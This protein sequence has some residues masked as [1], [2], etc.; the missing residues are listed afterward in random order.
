MLGCAESNADAPPRDASP[1]KT[2][3]LLKFEDTSTAHDFILFHS[4][5][6]FSRDPSRAETC[7]PIRIHHLLLQDMSRLEPGTA[8]PG[9]L[10]RVT[11]VYELPT[12][13]V[14]LERMDSVVTGRRILS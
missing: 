14:C 2:L 11:S 13:P 8:L 4:G 3:V 10:R 1:N 7:H 5:T 9:L 12:C 6:T